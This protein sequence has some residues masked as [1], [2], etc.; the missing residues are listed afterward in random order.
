MKNGYW[1]TRTYISGRVG[2][3]TKYWVSGTRDTTA[4]GRRRE[5]AEIRKQE[6]NEYSAVKGL[7]RVLNANLRSGDILLGLDYSDEGIEKL[8]SWCRGQG[9]NV[10]SMSEEERAEAI[11]EAARHALVLCMRRVSRALAKNGIELR[12]FAAVT[13]DMDG[14]TGEAV[15]VHHHLVIPGEAREA[16]LAKW[17]HG[18]VHFK[19]IN[20]EQEDYTPLA[21]YL[22]RQVR[23]IPDEK[24]Y[25]TTRNIIRPIPRDRVAVSDAELRAPVGEKLLFRSEYKRGC[26]QYIRYTLAKG[27]GRGGGTYAGDMEEIGGDRI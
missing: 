3:K 10:D 6:Q 15:R 27:R 12:C 23:R 26:P 16:F 21:E 1:V 22:L 18:G 13:S 14:E 17:K 9:M 2:E 20:P 4:R 8:L 25:I 11:R 5:K 24:K 19:G 7:A